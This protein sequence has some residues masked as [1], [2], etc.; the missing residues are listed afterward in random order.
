LP[1][2]LFSYQTSQFGYIL[3]GLGGEHV[4]TYLLSPFGK[5]SGHLE[6]LGGEHVGIGIL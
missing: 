1:D 5:F 6:G 3:E 2:S 4:G